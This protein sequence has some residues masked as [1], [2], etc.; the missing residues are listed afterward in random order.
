MTAQRGDNK[1][2]AG[3]NNDNDIG[4]DAHLHSWFSQHRLTEL[5]E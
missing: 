3:T 5:L 1:I 2:N 4:S